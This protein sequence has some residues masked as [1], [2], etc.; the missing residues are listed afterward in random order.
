MSVFLTPHSEGLEK[1]PCLLNEEKDL[2]RQ[3]ITSTE[4]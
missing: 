2:V 4:S 1:L 3:H